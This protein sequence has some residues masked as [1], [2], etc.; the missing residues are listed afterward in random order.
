MFNFWPFNIKRKREEHRRE[1][2]RMEIEFQLIREEA[3][4][5]LEVSAARHNGRLARKDNQSRVVATQ[6]QQADTTTA[7]V[8]GTMVADSGSCSPSSS[9]SS[10]SY[11]SSSYDSGSSF[12]SSGG[13]D[14]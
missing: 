6:H 12:S 7:F 3:K 2:E 13:G 5:A 9:G 4:K 14:C 11:S 1:I 10:S 8:A